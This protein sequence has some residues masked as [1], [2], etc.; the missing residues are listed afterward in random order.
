MRN[1][2]NCECPNHQIA[3]WLPKLVM[4]FLVVASDF[5]RPGLVSQVLFAP[6][7]SFWACLWCRCLAEPSCANTCGPGCMSSSAQ[8][9]SYFCAGENWHIPSIPH[10]AVPGVA[11]ATAYA[12]FK[13]LH[14]PEHKVASTI[15]C[16]AGLLG[17]FHGFQNKCIWSS[18]RLPPSG[19][20]CLF[21]Q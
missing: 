5:R 1:G 20:F 18:D 17:P 2:D 10:R 4:P 6:I 9:P 3:F 21:M 11:N 7:F 16:T 12:D 15:C 14:W 8:H 13:L 19:W